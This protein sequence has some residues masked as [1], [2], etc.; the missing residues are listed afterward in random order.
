MILSVHG[1]WAIRRNRPP[2]VPKMGHNT[3]NGGAFFAEYAVIAS[4]SHHL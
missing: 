2:N 3:V 4:L 1:P